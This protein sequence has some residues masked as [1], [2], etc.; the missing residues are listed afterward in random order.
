M[1]IDARHGE[2]MFPRAQWL[3]LHLCHETHCILLSAVADERILASEVPGI[4][5]DLGKTGCGCSL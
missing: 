1:F 2:R 4:D 5:D 3:Y